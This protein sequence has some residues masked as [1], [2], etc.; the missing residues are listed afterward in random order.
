MKIQWS[1]FFT[2]LALTT[3]VSCGAEQFGTAAKS[4]S[5]TADP[6]RV[7]EQ[8]SCSSYTLVKPK[9]DIIYL[10]DNTES[11]YY[12]SDSLKSAINGTLNQVS[13][14]FDYRIITT[15]LVNPSQDILENLSNGTD[16][17]E[18]RVMTNS[19]DNLPSGVS[20]NK[21]ISVSELTSFINP[22]RQA[23]QERGLFRLK[24][25]MERHAGT[26][27]LRQGAYNLVVLISN[28]RDSEVERTNSNLV[29][30]PIPGML[31]T[32]Y[33]ELTAL[34]NQLN[35]KDLRLFSI[36]AKSRCKTDQN[37]IP[38]THS[39]QAMSAALHNS[40]DAFDLC[41]GSFTD[42]FASV[43]A[44][45]QQIVIPHV[46]KFWPITFADNSVNITDF[47]DIQVFKMSGN[48]TSNPTLIP[49]SRYTYSE[50]GNAS[51]QPNKN[52]LVTSDP[53]EI[54]TGRR[55]FIRFNSDTEV[56]YPDCIQ[57]KSTSRT[58]VFNY[59]VLQRPPQVGTMN[60]I[61][62]GQSIP[63]SQNGSDGWVYE[64]YKSVPNIKVYQ[65]NGSHLPE[66]PKS[67]Y[68]IR[69]IGESYYYKSG[70][71]VQVNYIPSAI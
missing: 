12:S 53:Q 17:S 59:I 13:S 38:A 45:I 30:E 6:L 31:T 24:K 62:R 52:I 69:I 28:S 48:G 41:S 2:F 16:N 50:N 65:A 61:V 44:S 58:E 14:Q 67:G 22:L 20:N 43:N 34:K 18:Y 33:N 37:W 42:V 64:G 68:M 57:I 9:V 11:Y 56:T 3:L 21:V 70:D 4:T 35:S 32:R 26:G 39:Y 8:S 27:L 49:Q 60:V 66:L 1:A 15:T 5:S 40:S 54:V 63:Q 19:S 29:N 47:S 51:Y 46:Y 25:F 36:T 7:Y 10:I 71:S 23:H 55:H